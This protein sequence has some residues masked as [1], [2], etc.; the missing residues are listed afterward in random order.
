MAWP[1]SRKNSSLDNQS[2]PTEIQEYYQAE[3]RER[4]GV[5]WLLA[6]VTLVVTVA[7]VLGLFAGGR[8]AYR[9]LANQDQPKPD[10]AQEA[11]DESGG[12]TNTPD[13]SEDS[14]PPVTAPAPTPAPRPTA[15]APS[16]TPAPRPTTPTTGR[17]NVPATGPADT[18]GIFLAVSII[19]TFAHARFAKR[20]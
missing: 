10:T 5:A 2:I 3:S 11:T 14:L 1:F 13:D 18:L 20:S 19:G 6:L 8:W 15:P 7:L 4:R 17:T 12:T 16:P 9:K